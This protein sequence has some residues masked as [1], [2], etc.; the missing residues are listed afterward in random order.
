M[1]MDLKP[2]HVIAIIVALITGICSIAASYVAGKN[3]GE[4][5]VRNEIGNIL[6]EN[7]IATDYTSLND[8]IVKLVDANSNLNKKYADVQK[9]NAMLEEQKKNLSEENQRLKDQIDSIEGNSVSGH[10][11]FDSDLRLKE[12]TN[13]AITTPTPNTEVSPNLPVRIEDI[14]ILGKKPYIGDGIKDSYGNVYPHSLN[15]GGKDS[16][17]LALQGKY[18]EMNFGLSY[19]YFSTASNGKTKVM[20]EIYGDDRLIWSSDWVSYKSKMQEYTID[21]SGIDILKLETDGGG[22]FSGLV[23]SSLTFTP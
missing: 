19:Y 18:S 22:N 13:D 7:N 3:T 12:N 23:L 15:I 8:T 20:L 14:T 17:E 5:N 10:Q 4:T 9:D 11:S 6:V 21:V 2:K 16:C 1:K